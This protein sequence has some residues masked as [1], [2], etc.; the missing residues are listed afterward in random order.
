MFMDGFADAMMKW[1]SSGSH[2]HDTWR[3]NLVSLLGAEERPP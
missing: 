1:N 3:V 2:A